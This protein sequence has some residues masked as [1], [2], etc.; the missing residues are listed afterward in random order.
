MQ[1]TLKKINILIN[2]GKRWIF[3]LLD[4]IHNHSVSVDLLF[5]WVDEVDSQLFRLWFTMIDLLKF[6]IVDKQ[7]KFFRGNHNSNYNDNKSCTPNNCWFL[8]VFGNN[9]WQ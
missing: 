2:W 6:W 3:L 1:S 7:S 8:W 4:T 5:P 9:N